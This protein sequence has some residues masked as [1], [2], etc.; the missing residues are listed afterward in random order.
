MS[1]Q[2]ILALILLAILVLFR[3]P[4]EL[5]FSKVSAN[6]TDAFSSEI[7]TESLKTIELDVEAKSAY[8]VDI[9]DGKVLFQKNADQKRPLASLTKLMTAILTD[10]SVPDGAFIPISRKA[11]L[12]PQAEGLE[13]GDKIK[14]E[15][16]LDIMMS[17]S[18]N[19]AAHAASEF[20]S[21]NPSSFIADMNKK[22]AELGFENLSFTNQSGLDILSQNGWVPGAMGNAKDIAKLFGFIYKNYPRLLEKTREVSFDIKSEAGRI[23]T[24]KNTNEALESIPNFIGG[25]TGYT[26]LAGGNLVFMF[27]P[28]PVHQVIVSLL[29]SSE[30]GR[31]D[32]A[33]RLTQAIL[34]Y[35]GN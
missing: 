32:D 11:Y 9:A 31:F 22:A 16:V 29:G 34:E 18:S 33:R 8:V 17:A 15:D 25:K 12:E 28:K 26:K 4:T 30:T 24:A 3:V 6:L 7:K 35:Y 2:I 13:E 14:K 1:R 21:G 20:V 23:I 10:D 19:D 27:E 5:P